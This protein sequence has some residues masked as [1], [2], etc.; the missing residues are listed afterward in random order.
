MRLHHRRDLIASAAAITVA[1]LL[2]AC[3]GSTSSSASSAV[4]ASLA[5]GMNA[6]EVLTNEEIAAI[7]GSD[8]GT[9]AIDAEPTSC[10]YSGGLAVSIVP[11]D[12]SKSAEALMN[13]AGASGVLPLDRVGEDAAYA[14]FKD[15]GIVLLVAR[16]GVAQVGVYLPASVDTAS[17]LA[18]AML[19]KLAS[20]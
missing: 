16:Q 18:Q 7:I 10:S 20:G 2:A 17:K 8:P 12:P 1:V 4:P 19:D 9:A 6:C 3:S 5:A 15:Q 13:E 11:A 14:E